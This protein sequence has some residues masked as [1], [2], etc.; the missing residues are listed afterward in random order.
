MNRKAVQETSQRVTLERAC[1]KSQTA[2]MG[3][4]ATGQGGLSRMT[5]NCHVR[6]LG[7]KGSRDP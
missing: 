6:F 3:C 4:E 2:L 1:E 7:G 5:G